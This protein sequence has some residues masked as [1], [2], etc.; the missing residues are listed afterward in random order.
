MALSFTGKKEERPLIQEGKY[1][2]TLNSEWAKTKA[3]DDYIKLT[4]TIRKDVEQN[5]QGRLVFD[6]L[7]K[8]KTTGQFPS[9]K[10]NAI[11]SAI[12]NAKLD[13][14][15]Y[16]ELIQYLNDVNMIVEIVTEKADG[17][18][19]LQNDRSTVKFWSNE[20]TIAGPVFLEKGA[21]EEAVATTDLPF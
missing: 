9:S 18:N 20:P 13:F 17:A 6:G 10:I 19:A 16:D 5:E 2:V 8:S 3:G 12:P 1:E 4:Y 15:S 7:Y 21:V 11:L 14:D